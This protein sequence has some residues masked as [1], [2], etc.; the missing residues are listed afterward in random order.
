MY[1][2]QPLDTGC[3]E[4]SGDLLELTEL[5]AKNTHEVWAQQRI[6]EGWQYGEKRDDVLKL[7]P[8]LVL[9]E[10]LP[11][12]EKEYDRNTAMETLKVIRKLGFKIKK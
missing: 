11:E 12:S 7:H 4:L 6:S 10:E 3:I 1:K 2:L 5:L 8:C 9:Y